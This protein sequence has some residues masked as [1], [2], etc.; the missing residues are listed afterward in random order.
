MFWLKM[1]Q[2]SEHMENKRAEII[3]QSLGTTNI[4]KTSST[5]EGKTWHNATSSNLPLQ[6][7]NSKDI[8]E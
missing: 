4:V 8:N 1:V 6:I 5:L 2:D 7:M 3:C